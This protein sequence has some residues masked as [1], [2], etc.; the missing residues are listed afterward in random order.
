MKSMIGLFSLIYLIIGTYFFMASAAFLCRILFSILGL[1]TVHAS[2]REF[3]DDLAIGEGIPVNNI[4]VIVYVP[5]DVYDIYKE[6]G[7]EIDRKINII[8]KMVEIGLNKAL[9]KIKSERYFIIT[10]HIR[11]PPENINNKICPNTLSRMSIF[12][13]SIYDSLGG[14]SSFIYITPC[15]LPELRKK[16]RNLGQKDFYISERI[17]GTHKTMNLIS[18]EIRPDLLISSLSRAILK[19]C[20]LVDIE[21][22]KLLSNVDSATGVSF[23]LDVRPE[24][25]HEILLK[26]YL[27]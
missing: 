12:L 21:P 13:A 25:A 20:D 23:G 17:N 3:E 11:A 24:T 16:V 8:F 26:E 19:A 27:L 7:I 15:P 4:S 14:R 5:S 10:P 1:L 9:E 6:R 2:R 18:V 22:L